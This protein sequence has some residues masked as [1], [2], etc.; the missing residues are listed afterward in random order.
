MCSWIVCCRMCDEDDFPLK[1]RSLINV[2]TVLA[3]T[4]EHVQ[5]VK[6][7]VDSKLPEGFPKQLDV[8]V[9]PT[10]SAR[11]LIQK[12]TLEL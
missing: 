8:P 10:I 4:G 12:C 7:F 5:K 1:L 11:V 2:F 3:P 9:F 6:L